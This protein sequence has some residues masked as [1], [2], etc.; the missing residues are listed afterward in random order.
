MKKMVDCRVCGASVAK[1][2]NKC[3]HCGAHTPNKKNFN[4]A[5]VGIILIGVWVIIM[6]LTAIGGDDTNDASQATAQ[7]P[8]PEASEEPIP[9]YIEISAETLWTAYQDNEVKA[10]LLYGEK[11]LAVTGTVT[12]IGKDIVTEAPCISLDSGNAYGLYP[13]QCFFPKN[14]EQMEKLAAL[15]DGDVVT[16]YGTCTGEFVTTVQLSRCYL[17]IEE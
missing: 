11:L 3:P 14:R 9:E 17:A 5:I 6:I 7:Q 4:A 2:A 12:D 13:I 10:D 15:S 16:I 1:N 8:N